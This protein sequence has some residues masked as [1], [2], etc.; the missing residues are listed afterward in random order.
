MGL[1]EAAMMICFGASWPMAIWKTWRSKNPAGKSFRFQALIMLGYVCGII[2]KVIYT[3]HDWVVWL[4]A[5]NLLLV[6]I[7]SALMLLYRGR[8]RA[9]AMP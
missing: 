1:W 9:N 6:A 8:R 7:D 3:P 5:L 2:H 4:Y